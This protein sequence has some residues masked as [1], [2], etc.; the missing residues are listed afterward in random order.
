[1]SD[2]HWGEGGNTLYSSVTL[3]TSLSVLS[4]NVQRLNGVS[5][6]AACLNFIEKNYVDVALI[7]ESHLTKKSVKSFSNSNYEVVASSSVDD[8]TK[9]VLIVIRRLLDIN[10]TDIGSD[11]EGRIAFVKAIMS[12]MKIVFVSAYALANYDKK[13]LFRTIQFINI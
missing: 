10:I 1:M 8:K 6:R 12:N 3:M 9:G 7:Q 11:N 4:W 2:L 13:I 5:K